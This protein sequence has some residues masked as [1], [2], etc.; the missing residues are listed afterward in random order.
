MSDCSDVAARQHPL[1][2]R[3]AATRSPVARA[4]ARRAASTPSARP[5]TSR[6]V[7][8]PCALAQRRMIPRRHPPTGFSRTCRGSHRPWRRHEPQRRHESRGEAPKGHHRDLGTCCLSLGPPRDPPA[9]AGCCHSGLQCR[10]TSHSSAAWR[11]S[12]L[13]S[14]R[15]VWYSAYDDLSGI[16]W[17]A[18]A[19][20]TRLQINCNIRGG[21]WRWVSPRNIVAACWTRAACYADVLVKHLRLIIIMLQVPFWM[22]TCNADR[23]MWLAD[24]SAINGWNTRRKSRYLGTATTQSINMTCK[25]I[26][27]TKCIIPNLG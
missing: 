4:R 26:T 3:R 17:L 12:L 5:N 16:E 9:S 21:S 7:A 18:S 8:S 24:Q 22:H 19:P 23:S 6:P 13:D 2:T 10:W 1:S 14:S 27:T 15:V 11:R 25:S 20:N